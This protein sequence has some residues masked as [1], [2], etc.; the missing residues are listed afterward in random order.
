MMAGK[1]TITMDVE[2]LRAFTRDI[3]SD[4]INALLTELLT[5]GDIIVMAYKAEPVTELMAESKAWL[6]WKAA[7]GTKQDAGA[8]D[9]GADKERD[10]G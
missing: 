3:V 8:S 10:G 5:S 6:E 2:A 4:T 7:Q 1:T 9:A